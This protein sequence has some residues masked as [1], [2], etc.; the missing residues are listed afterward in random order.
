MLAV[1]TKPKTE[2]KYIF[3]WNDIIL[4]YTDNCEKI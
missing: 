2:G 1:K 4:V 3:K